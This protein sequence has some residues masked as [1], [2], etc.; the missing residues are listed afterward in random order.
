MIRRVNLP[1][2]G[3]FFLYAGFLA[4]LMLIVHMFLWQRFTIPSKSML[5][6]LPVGASV[7]VKPSYFGVVNP[8]TLD[9]IITYDAMPTYGQI[10]IARFP[11]S[12]DVQYIKRVVALPGDTLSVGA[13]GIT[14]NSN[15]FPFE[16]LAE[17]QVDGA[18]HIIVLKGY[19]Y[20]VLIDS[21]RT[22]MP[23][24]EYIVDEDEVFLLGD[25]LT[26]SVDS[27]DL[28]GFKISNLLAVVR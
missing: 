10:V 4:V 9:K 5:P 12:A 14:I 23:I 21:T 6:S 7:S 2:F 18:T 19:S 17:K 16:L 28:G 3:E 26:G 15:V 11:Y 24:S 1:K 20:R 8:F 22:L 13:A 25:N 27:R